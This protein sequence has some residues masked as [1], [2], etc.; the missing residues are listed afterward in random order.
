MPVMRIARP[1]ILMAGNAG[2]T[3][4]YVEQGVAKGVGKDDI[5]TRQQLLVTG[6]VKY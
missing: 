5:L 2:T 6:S 1:R 3:E 4:L